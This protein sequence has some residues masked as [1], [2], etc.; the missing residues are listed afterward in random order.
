M[1]ISLTSGTGRI[2][3]RYLQNLCF[4]QFQHIL[5]IFLISDNPSFKQ[6]TLVY[7]GELWA[8]SS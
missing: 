5:F 6:E 4:S 2:A 8:N 3:T 1:F 7:G